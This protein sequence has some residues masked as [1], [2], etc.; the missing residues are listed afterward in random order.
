MRITDYF[1]HLRCKFTYDYMATEEYNFIEHQSDS[2]V[3]FAIYYFHDWAKPML[4]H[5]HKMSF[6]ASIVK[7]LYTLDL[8]HRYWEICQN[9]INFK[10]FLT[11]LNFIS[12]MKRDLGY[13]LN[14]NNASNSNFKFDFGKLG[15]TLLHIQHHQ[16]QLLQVECH[17]WVRTFSN[18]RFLLKPSFRPSV[19]VGKS[20]SI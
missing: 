4:I 2:A 8:R 7:F 14:P 1:V 5:D 15:N 17:S 13:Q 18:G 10:E 20:D 12:F 9:S 6:N 3:H 11:F 19:R 16:K